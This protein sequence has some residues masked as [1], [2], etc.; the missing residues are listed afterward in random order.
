[1]VEKRI[2]FVKKENE[3]LVKLCGD[4]WIAPFELFGL[5]LLKQY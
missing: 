2:K 3:V 4:H 1:M 5:K